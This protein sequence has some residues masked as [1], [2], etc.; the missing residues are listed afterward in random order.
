MKS[1]TVARHIHAPIERVYEL[2]T[3]LEHAADR[4][5][6]LERVEMLSEGPFGVG[7][8]WRETRT[9]F[10][11][12]ATEEMVIASCEPPNMYVADAASHGSEYRSIW[13]FA[14]SGDG[15]DVAMEFQAT[16]VSLMA[17][18]M[19]PLAG[20]MMKSVVKLLE[21]DLDDLAKVA[22]AKPQA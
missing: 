18:L 6:G 2:F 11:K 22:E 13:R 16:P 4:I 17:K 10:G 20:L 5:K 3:D 14:P 1:V 21:A 7:T 8:R 15:T 19:T 12:E 9:M